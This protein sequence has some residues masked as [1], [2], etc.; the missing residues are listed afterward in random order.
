[1]ELRSPISLTFYN[2]KGAPMNI[3]VALRVIALTGLLASS[4]P[5]RA[6]LLYSA[7]HIA[8]LGGDIVAGTALNGYGEVTGYADTAAGDRHAFQ[9]NGTTTKDLG[10][11]GGTQSTGNAINATGQVTGSA[12]LAGDK[13]QHAFVWN[14]TKMVDLGTLGGSNSE[15]TAINA[16]GEVTGWSDMPGNTAQ[17]AF[18]WNGTTMKDLGTLGGTN[19]AGVA[20]NDGG[21]VAG[22]SD[23]AGDT[24]SHTFLWNGTS[25]KD[26]GSVV[27][28]AT[29]VAPAAMNNA[30]QVVGTAYN[31]SRSIET[32]FLWDGT[33]MVVLNTLGKT[34]F[35]G[36]ASIN[37]KGQITGWAQLS[38]DK[39]GHGYI[40]SA[41]TAVRMDAR[42]FALNPN[43]AECGGGNDIAT[44][45]LA[46]GEFC[47]IG[48]WVDPFLWDGFSVLDLPGIIKDD[49]PELYGGPV[50]VNN[51]GQVLIHNED[52]GYLADVVSPI[53]GAIELDVEPYL[54][55][56][57]Q[58]VAG[59]VFSP[60]PA[61]A[62][63]LVVSLSDDLAATSVPATVTIPAG[64]T[65]AP[66]T[67]TTIPV[68][69]EQD[70]TV[71]ATLGKQSASAG[72]YI[73]PIGVSTI[74]LTPSTVIGGKTVAGTVNLDCGAA[75]ANITVTLSSSNT[76]DATPV[77][78]TITIP[79]GQST[80][81]FQVTTK[82]VS[83]RVLV[84]IQASANSV[85]KTANLKLNK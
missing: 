82:K 72:L 15:G 16:T 85:K 66:F 9:W 81:S 69:S 31:S 6:Q 48:G 29:T 28:G 67:I 75:P 45:G 79:K 62:G 84:T 41:T 11:L 55:A 71:T 53:P 46:V 76:A 17:H 68:T 37:A 22:S 54:A 73:R 25:K 61:P 13:K 32:G 18:L 65:G 78:S 74:T 47:D 10:T 8:T 19:S 42:I 36:A 77:P 56:G 23:I 64:A 38:T 26:L 3:S 83:S 24:A 39:K 1:M 33:K 34:K 63:G 60:S 58:D 2:N 44:D 14:G 59:F 57:C 12:N 51:Q 50:Y 43:A 52:S 80:A 7:R 49:V 4:L 70:G 40:W 35:S 30:G 27:A 20:I 21:Q 5:A